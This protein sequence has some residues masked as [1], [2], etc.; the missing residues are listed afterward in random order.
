MLQIAHLVPVQ[1]APASGC[2]RIRWIGVHQLAAV[3]LVPLKEA[4]SVARDEAPARSTIGGFDG[5]A[6][7][8]STSTL[9]LASGSGIVRFGE[10]GRRRRK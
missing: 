5:G 4:D 2:V 1:V 10:F 7:V 8:W 6:R 9:F 3:E